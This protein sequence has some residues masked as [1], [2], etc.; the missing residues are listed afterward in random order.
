MTPRTSVSRNRPLAPSRACRDPTYST[1][2][3]IGGYA[4]H[5][6]TYVYLETQLFRLFGPDL[7]IP[8]VLNA[9]LGVATA[10]FI[11]GSGTHLFGRRAALLA[12]GIVA[13][14][15]SL[16]LWS[17][18]NLRDPLIVALTT[19]AV[20]SLTSFAIRP[21]AIALIVP[22]VATAELV[23]LRGYVAATIA[24]IAVVTVLVSPA[25]RIRQRVVAGLAAVAVAVIIV[26]QSAGSVGVNAADQLLEGVERER[27][28]ETIGA[29]T[30]FAPSISSD[31]PVLV[32]TVTY[33]PTGLAY[34]LLEPVPLLASR[35]QELIA[36]PEMLVWYALCALAVVTL[37][38]E[39]RRWQP[40][41]PSTLTIV[42]L[43]VLL[44]LLEGNVGGL[45]RHR[46]A[47]V[48]FVALLAAPAALR[49][50]DRRTRRVDR[51]PVTSASTVAS[52]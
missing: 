49:L 40:L 41:A 31:A 20:W 28:A 36:A 12:A 14:Y 24:S 48:P 30:A 18:L 8:L 22:L 2:Q 13:F 4:Y 25:L 29:N 38:R 32:R 11:Y 3:L 19:L 6:G 10:I 47:V 1:A 7:R 21:R 37:W 34:A 44:A 27:V 35:T 51:E 23:N 5:F 43:L 42:G 45:F 33:L 52:R 15:P 9:S 17:S 26:L 16:V 46:G 50:Y 39:R